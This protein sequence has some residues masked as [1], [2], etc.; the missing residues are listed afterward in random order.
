L[1]CLIIRALYMKS[2]KFFRLI[3]PPIEEIF[4][5]IHIG[6]CAHIR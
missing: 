6:H 2:R 5:K 3:S 4:L 1:I